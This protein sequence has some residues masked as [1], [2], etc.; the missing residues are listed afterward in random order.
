LNTIFNQSNLK[1]ESK[2]MIE[3]TDCDNLIRQ[4]EM[5]KYLL[6]ID[7]PEETVQAI[8][9]QKISVDYSLFANLGGDAAQFRD[10]VFALI[11]T[12][13]Q[14]AKKI[15]DKNLRLDQELP[16]FGYLF[17]DLSNIQQWQTHTDRIT[18]QL[19]RNQE[20][21]LSYRTD[22]DKT[23]TLLLKGGNYYL[24]LNDRVRKAFIVKEAD[25]KVAVVI[26]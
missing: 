18:F 16:L 8:I 20:H 6:F 15:D 24:K 1:N 11:E 12:I 10:K 26:N 4:L 2:L 3:F 25:Q 9:Q 5:P 7:L 17:L 14:G 19:K 13:D 23:K 21:W 22:T